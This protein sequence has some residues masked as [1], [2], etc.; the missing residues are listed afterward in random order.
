MQ[1]ADTTIP[2]SIMN[3]IDKTKPAIE[4]IGLEVW[5]EAELSQAEHKSA[6]IHLRQLEA[7]GFKITS[8]KTCG[9]AAAFVAEWSQGTGGARIGFLSEYDALPG[10]GNRP[11]VSKSSAATGIRSVTVAA[12]TNS[13]QVHGRSNCT[14][15]GDGEGLHPGDSPGLRMCLR[16]EG[17]GQGTDV[18]RRLV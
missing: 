1:P 11:S 12:T 10:L 3:A 2:A 14:Q 8:T 9:Y 18:A 13:A 4:R 7:A 17:G 15:A 6:Q 16:S 5:N